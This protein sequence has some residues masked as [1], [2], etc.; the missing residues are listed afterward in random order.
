MLQEHSIPY[1]SEGSYTREGWLQFKCPFCLGGQD[2]NKPYCGYNLASNYV[3]CWVCGPHRVL[4]TLAALTGE[5]TAKLATIVDRLETTRPRTQE[6]KRGKLKLPKGVG[7]LLGAHKRYLRG[8][9]FDPKEL[10]RLWGIGGIGINSR[11]SWRIFIPIRSKGEVVS[12]TTRNLT[13]NGLRYISADSTEEVVNHKSLLYGE[14]YCRHAIVIHEGPLD[15]WTTGPGAVCT[16]GTGFKRSQVLR[17]VEYPVR[18]VCFDA[19]PVAQRRARELCDLLEVFPGETMNIV[20]SGKDAN[21]T[22]PKE[23]RW[24]K[25]N[26]LKL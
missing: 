23:I 21:E 12:W 6:A 2:P 20:L 9:G 24:L 26:V 3:N 15:V 16:F 22:D 8:R 25:K 18:A 19:E 11:L 4:D 5:S 17:M 1:R 10:V 14:D 13:Q 7:P